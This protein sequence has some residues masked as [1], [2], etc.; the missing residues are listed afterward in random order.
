MV[1]LGHIASTRTRP[2][3]VVKIGSASL[4]HPGVFDELAALHRGGASLLVVAGG[5]EGIRRHYAATGRP[6]RF[7]H[8]RDGRQVRYCPAEEMEHIVAAYEHDTLARVRREVAA[9]GLTLHA[10][11]A[12]GDGLVRGRMNGPLRT[13]RDG[14]PA[15]VRDH[16]AGTVTAIDARRLRHLLSAF[17][18]VCLS[19]PVADLDGGP[20]LNVDADV[21]AAELANALDADHLRLV[22]GTPGLLADRDDPSSRLADV[23][24][25]QGGRHARGRM[26]Q[27]V[28]AAEIAM[29]G[30]ADIAVTGPHTLDAARGSRFWRALP[31]ADDL[32][33]LSRAVEISSVSRDERELATYLAG[34]CL[35]R[36]V[37]ARVDGAGNLVATRGTGPRRLLMLGHLDTVDHRWPV[38]W[39]G[40]T[41]TGRGCVD[42][43]GSLA[44]FL[45]V[46]AGLDVPEGGQVRVVGAVEEEM[47]SRGAF[48]VRDAYP[49]DAVIA[50]EPSGAGALTVS[51]NGLVKL[52]L[53]LRE[54][55]AHGAGEG[56]S[57]AADQLVDA[58]TT[59]RATLLGAYPGTLCTT[60]GIHSVNA[61]DASVGSTVIDIRVPRDVDP[62]DVA[63]RMGRIVAPVTCEVLR[64]TPWAGT[65]RADPLVRAF[66]RALRD[67]GLSPRY[68]AKKGSSDLNTLAT[69]WRR[70]PMVAYGPGDSALDH[71][72][73]ERLTASEYRL[74][75]DV[76][77]AAVRNWLGGTDPVPPWTV[78]HDT[79]PR[80]ASGSRGHGVRRQRVLER[81]LDDA[82]HRR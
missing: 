13:I 76:L 70:V 75:R 22:T 36:G 16:R 6:L 64:A 5:A 7:L 66:T 69:T 57:T 18:V 24:A 53:S 20:Q 61:G 12:A 8:L 51:Y 40:D 3:H 27:K 77:G 14:R 10:A 68:L 67:A 19:P 43:K 33:L 56:T 21:L 54:P 37:D 45:E 73:V 63:D 50:G 25:G 59:I 79:Q 32:L 35:E 46:L 29:A 48:H 28:R 55:A 58:V 49:A 30:T 62:A 47:T 2:L 82:L 9:R 81:P 26:L 78:G 41:L 42:A 15:V 74:G 34:W 23:A 65:G 60:L 52:R 31:P 11:V 44:A 72:P 80:A 1:D 17:D 4:G 38:R 39:T 71:T